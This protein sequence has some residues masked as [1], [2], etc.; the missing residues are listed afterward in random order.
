[1]HHPAG[2][3][4]QPL[5]RLTRHSTLTTRHSLSIMAEPEQGREGGGETL[6]QRHLSTEQFEL[7]IRRAAELQASAAEAGGEEMSEGEIV[8]IGRELGLSGRYLQQ[9]LA[10]VRGRG[11]RGAGRAGAGDGRGGPARGP[12]RGDGSR[13]GTAAA[14]ALPRGPRVHERASPLPRPHPLRARLGGGGDPGA[15][16]QRGLHAHA[17]AQAAQPGGRGA[18][19]GGGLQLRLPHLL[20]DATAGGVPGGR[21]AGGWGG[22]HGGRHLPRHRR[23]ASRSRWSA[24][25]WPASS[26]V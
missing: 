11:R 6:P 3:A 14:G 22:R 4:A 2:G 12:H 10:E 1:M 21:G 19:A 18:A 20:A 16:G 9:A 17:A 7:V 24:C 13:R 15:G 26:T 25:P 8:R 5:H 23:R